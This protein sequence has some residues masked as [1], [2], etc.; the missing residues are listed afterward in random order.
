MEW[1]AQANTTYR[2][3]LPSLEG[4]G[5][6]IK[7]RY[8]IATPRI[9]ASA[10]FLSH[11]VPVTHTSLCAVHVKPVL[12]LDCLFPPFSCS[13][14]RNV[15]SACSVNCL[16]WNLLFE[17]FLH[18][19]KFSCFGTDTTGILFEFTMTLLVWVAFGI[20]VICEH[21]MQQWDPRGNCSWLMWTSHS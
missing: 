20:C 15:F 6:K 16:E 10:A 7:F 21:E 9:D 13:F 5:K 3:L 12:F 18:N 11:F 8:F 17:T 19:G 14:P 1:R 4:S 2:S